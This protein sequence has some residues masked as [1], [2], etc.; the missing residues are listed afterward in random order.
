MTSSTPHTFRPRPFRLPRA[1]YA[2]NVLL[3]LALAVLGAAPVTALAN[4][5]AK[6]PAGVAPS[7]AFLL[8]NTV[9]PPY[10][11]ALGDGGEG[12]TATE[13]ARELFRRL[14]IPLRQ[15][16]LPWN[17]V[18]RMMEEG[19]ADG[20][21]MLAHSTEREASMVFSVPVDE[22]RQ[23]FYYARANLQGFDWTRYEDLHPYRIGLVQGYTYAPEFLAAVERAG[24]SVEYAPSDESNFAKLRTGR[25]DLCLS[26]DTV[27]EAYLSSQPDLD[28]AVGK[29]DRPVRSYPL[30]M[31]F[32]RRSPLA[33]RLPEINRELQRMHADGTLQRILS[34]E[35][36][37]LH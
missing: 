24:L 16:L 3:W 26:N 32:S 2:L 33:A 8:L 15:R 14:D 27:A 1:S 4:E 25:V 9:Y 10:T 5:D 23:S 34:A 30:Y 37:A 28:A 7:G 6:P 12:G 20:V 19:S 36:P 29:A 21:T 35:F 22:A 17:R 31:A 11:V 13:L 18:L